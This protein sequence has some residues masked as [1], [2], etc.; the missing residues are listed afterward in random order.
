VPIKSNAVKKQPEVKNKTKAQLRSE[1][2]N[3]IKS[4]FIDHK[5]ERPGIFDIYIKK[6]KI[7]STNQLMEMIE[8]IKISIN[9]ASSNKLILVIKFK[10]ESE[11]NVFDK[12]DL[13]ERN[14]MLG[15]GTT[16]LT[17]KIFRQNLLISVVNGL[18]RILMN[19]NRLNENDL[20]N[21]EKSVQSIFDKTI[22]DIPR[23]LDSTTIAIQ[24]VEKIVDEEKKE[25]EAYDNAI[26]N[27]KSKYDEIE[28]CLLDLM[29]M[30]TDN[31]HYQ[32]TPQENGTL[33][34]TFGIIGLN[35]PLML[36]DKNID[37][38]K[39]LNTIK[40]RVEYLHKDTIIFADIDKNKL[41]LTFD[42]NIPIPRSKA[43]DSSGV[44]RKAPS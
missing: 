43:V 14:Y 9:Y 29:E 7:E 8:S 42:P 17:F 23:I 40:K 15:T 18:P 21:A 30:T 22:N 38:I 20:K 5:K 37:V 39:S 36:N 12:I 34:Y 41:I 3:S 4:D 32:K 31:K 44:K 11:K 6:D 16:T 2:F 33:I 26:N 1:L 25:S 13:A 24:E 19:L 27:F 10:K 35:K 28:D